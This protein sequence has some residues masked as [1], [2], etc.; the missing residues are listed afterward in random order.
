MTFRGI[1]DHMAGAYHMTRRFTG[2]TKAT[3]TEID[4][5]NES[6]FVA[7]PLLEGQALKD[8]AQARG[9]LKRVQVTVDDGTVSIA[10]EAAPDDRYSQTSTNNQEIVR[11][12]RTEHGRHQIWWQASAATFEIHVEF[13]IQDP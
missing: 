10:D 11:E 9:V 12:Y 3:W 2:Q 6:W 8:A 5:R 7:C 13:D 4:F 1:A